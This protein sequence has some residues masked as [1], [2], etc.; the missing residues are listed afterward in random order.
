MMRAFPPG[1]TTVPLSL[2]AGQR[3]V[4]PSL[5]PV[6]GWTGDESTGVAEILTFP[7]DLLKICAP[8]N[9]TYACNLPAPEQKAPPKANGRPAKAASSGARKA[10]AKLLASSLVG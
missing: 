5:E 8:Q 10:E 7:Q 3:I 1:N 9:I 4:S 2:A 6:L